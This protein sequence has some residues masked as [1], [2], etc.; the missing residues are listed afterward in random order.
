M[1]M[2]LQA[3]GYQGIVKHTRPKEVVARVAE[4]RPDVLLLNLMMPDVTGLDILGAMQADPSLREIRVV[5]I[6]SSTDPRLK[7][8]ALELGAIDFLAKPVDP[9]EL[10][11]RVR[12]ILA[13][14]SSRSGVVPGPP[15]SVQ[16]VR[17]RLA[18]EPERVQ[19]IVQQFVERLERNLA[20]I[21]ASFEARSL[22]ELAGLAH[23][24]KGSAGT[25]G[26]HE[27]TQPAETLGILAREGKEEEIATVIETLR[28]LADRIELPDALDG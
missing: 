15:P 14:R 2:F 5:I 16:T 8:K 12:N 13:A 20:A 4:I 7:R 22:E 26:L 21:E 19:A 28:D 25:V 18:G 23:W 10:A 17:S 9:S 3:E 11:L 24:L 1:E 6:T 27:F